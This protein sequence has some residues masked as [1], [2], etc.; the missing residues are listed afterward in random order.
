MIRIEVE[1]QE[2]ANYILEHL[3][4]QNPVIEEE[5]EELDDN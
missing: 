5:L 2:D 3:Q 4:T 1:T